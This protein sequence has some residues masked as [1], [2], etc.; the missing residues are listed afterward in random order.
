[1]TALQLIKDELANARETFTGTVG[2]ITAKQLHVDPGGK[3]STLAAAYAHLIFSEDVTIARLLQKK[4]PLYEIEWKD[5][6]GA[7]EPLPPMDENWSAANA[8][9]V[10]QVKVNLDQLNTYAQAVYAATDAYVA[11]LKD[12]DLDKEVDLG[13]WGKKTVAYLLYAFIIA[14]TNQLSGEISALKGMQGA[15][16]YTF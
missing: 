5:R 11:G 8:K 15:T 13:G 9:W 7:S 4:A 1:M 12:E 2:D 3:A 6:T 10:K 14:H 16:G